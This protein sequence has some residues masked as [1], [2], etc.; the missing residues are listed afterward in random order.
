MWNSGYAFKP[1]RVVPTSREFPF[2]R[3]SG[4]DVVPSNLASSW[5]PNG[6]ETLIGGTLQGRRQF[7]VRGA[8]RVCKKKMWK[9]ALEVAVVAG[10]PAVEGCLRVGKYGD[11]KSGELLEGR[12]K[13]KKEVREVL[14]GWVRNEGGEGFGGEGAE[15]C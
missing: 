4:N 10:V 7:D 2:S 13:V 8:S 12:R 9:L 5:T 14:G 3:R 1:F 15:P 11:V 6:S